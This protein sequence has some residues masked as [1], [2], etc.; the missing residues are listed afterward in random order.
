MFRIQGIDH[1]GLA[2]KDV[3]KSVDWY[4]ELLVMVNCK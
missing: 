3:Q 2:V 4:K 1:I